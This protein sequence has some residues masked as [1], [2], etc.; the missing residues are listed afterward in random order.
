MQSKL[1]IVEVKTILDKVSTLRVDNETFKSWKRTD[2][3]LK[4]QKFIKEKKAL[5]IEK[6]ISALT[7]QNRSRNQ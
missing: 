4:F 5:V 6:A 7:N 2:S 1:S 3:N